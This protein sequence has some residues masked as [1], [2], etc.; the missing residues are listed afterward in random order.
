MKFKEAKKYLDKGLKI[1]SV[2]K[3][4]YFEKVNDTYIRSVFYS[5]I[6]KVACALVK[7]F[8]E[9]PMDDADGFEIENRTDKEIMDF[10]KSKIKNNEK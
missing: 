7:D 3:D 1:S 9:I 8:N 6:G 10:V 5:N 2:K 4:G